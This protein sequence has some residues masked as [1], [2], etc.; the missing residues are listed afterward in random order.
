MPRL[1]QG[2]CSSRVR[3]PS[4]WQT[5]ATQLPRLR[6]IPGEGLRTGNLPPSH[7]P[8]LCLPKR[9]KDMRNGTRGNYAFVSNSAGVRRGVCATT[10]ATA[11]ATAH[12]NRIQLHGGGWSVPMQVDSRRQMVQLGDMPANLSRPATPATSTRATAPA[13][14][15]RQAIHPVCHGHRC[16]PLSRLHDYPGQ[17]HTYLVQLQ[18]WKHQQMDSRLRNGTGTSYLVDCF[19]WRNAPHDAGRSTLH[20][21]PP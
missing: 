4:L 18:V 17:H 13:P 7:T 15:L 12:Q 14:K 20:S 3:R 8:S 1:L 19:G 9:D 2:Q 10:A 16:A 6:Q 21:T 11:T 5:R